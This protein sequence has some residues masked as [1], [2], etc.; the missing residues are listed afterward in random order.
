MNLE[1]ICE[2]TINVRYFIEP[3]QTIE[4]YRFF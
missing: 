4:K 1:I 2:L 3:V